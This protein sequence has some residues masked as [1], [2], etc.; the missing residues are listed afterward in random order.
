MPTIEMAGMIDTSRELS[1]PI[2]AEIDVF[3]VD[4]RPRETVWVTV[5]K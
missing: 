2:I 3:S 1:D 4:T 5:E